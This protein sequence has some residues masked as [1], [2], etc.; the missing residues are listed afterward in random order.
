MATA[1]VTS[2]DPLRVH[3]RHALEYRLGPCTAGH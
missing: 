2:T 3:R 1:G